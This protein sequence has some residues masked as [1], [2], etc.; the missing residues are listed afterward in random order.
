MWPPFSFVHL[1]KLTHFRTIFIT[2]LPLDIH[3]G[4][5]RSGRGWSL[6]PLAAGVGLVWL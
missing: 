6:P 1:V 2:G 3:P 5:M 4:T